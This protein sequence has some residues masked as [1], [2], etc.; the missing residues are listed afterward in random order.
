MD[1]TRIRDVRLVL[2]L[3]FCMA[4]A[5][6]AH[7]SAGEVE[8]RA[9]SLAS[10]EALPV[11]YLPSVGSA[12]VL[13]LGHAS[14][15]ADVFW[16]RGLLYFNNEIVKYQNFQWIEHYIALINELD[17]HFRDVYMWGGMALMFSR[18]KITYHD[19]MQANAVMEPGL[20]R[21]PRDHELPSAMAA[22]C[23]FY[24][25]DPTPEQRVELRACVRKYMRVAAGREG[26]PYHVVLLA[27]Q[28]EEGEG[29]AGREAMCRFLSSMYLTKQDPQLRAQIEGRMRG[30]QC[31]EMSVER[32]RSMHETF[33]RVY[34]ETARY[35]PPD[36]AVQVFELR[37]PEGTSGLE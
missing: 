3:A 8:R 11:E 33:E 17:P 31:G 15:L 37:D 4:V 18:E 9:G 25:K 14:A 12:R 19:V 23:A 35:M 30:G 7:H 13:A 16:V 29:G 34:K 24:A 1:M 36:L 27:A 32:L 26:A 10:K 2:V 5:A 6:A 20:A 21:F 22:N 28:S